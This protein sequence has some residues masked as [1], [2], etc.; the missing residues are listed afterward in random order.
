MPSALTVPT[1]A[2]SGT[3][4]IPR[5]APQGPSLPQGASAPRGVMPH[6]ARGERG[7]I[8]LQCAAL[9]SVASA[10]GTCPRSAKPATIAH[11]VN[12][13]FGH[14]AHG[15]DSLNGGAAPNT[16]PK[17]T[18]RFGPISNRRLHDC[19][20]MAEKW[21][22]KE[23]IIVLAID[24]EGRIEIVTYGKTR[25]LCACAR[26]LGEAAFGAVLDVVRSADRELAG[27][28]PRHD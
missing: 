12:S 24:G 25:Q 28:L 3:R 6:P 22:G 20:A 18:E 26:V 9:G 1:P 13:S 19:R 10:P 14:S 17:L 4:T 7:C 27:R 11:A 15:A 16:E 23:Q 2:I 8:G 5:S 21:G